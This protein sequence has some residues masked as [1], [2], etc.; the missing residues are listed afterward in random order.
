MVENELVLVV[1]AADLRRELADPIDAE[2]RARRIVE[3]MALVFQAALVVA[4]SPPQVADAF[5]GSR[6]ARDWGY[7]YGTL[8][9][10]TD[11][12]VIVA[13]ATPNV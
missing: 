6:L 4:Q 7:A 1:E 2:R 10:G 9:P 12:A 11:A 5:C 3:R 13:R 8:P